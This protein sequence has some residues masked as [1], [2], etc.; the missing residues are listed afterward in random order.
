VQYFNPKEERKQMYWKVLRII[1]KDAK[2]KGYT[3]CFIWS[4]PPRK[5][6]EYIFNIHPKDQRVPNNTILRNWYVQF[7]IDAKEQGCVEDWQMLHDWMK[8]EPDASKYPWFDGDYLC[9]SYT[10]KEHTI[11]VIERNNDMFAC[12]L[13]SN[14]AVMTDP[15]LEQACLSF[16]ANRE[17]LIT[18]F[19]DYGL[20]FDTICNAKYSSYMTLW[21]LMNPKEYVSVMMCDHCDAFIY[22]KQKMTC[23]VANCLF[24]LCSS[25]FDLFGSCNHEHPLR[26]EDKDMSHLL[27][28]NH[29]DHPTHAILSTHDCLAPYVCNVCV[30]TGIVAHARI[31][32]NT[33]CTVFN[34]LK[35]QQYYKECVEQ[36]NLYRANLIT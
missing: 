5:G 3:M 31:C 10:T 6:D 19:H 13:N 12:T 30:N 25:C 27:N 23:S 24:V 21:F 22:T 15:P 1:L 29:C 2:T 14:T 32:K 28:C 20:Q 16:C 18:F 35:Y 17:Q 4:C 36:Y 26:M 8:N 33:L 11:E 7:L 34:C 9:K